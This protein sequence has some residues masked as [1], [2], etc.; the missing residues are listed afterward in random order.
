MKPI[1]AWAI[2]DRDGDACVTFGDGTPELFSSY[3]RARC[4][5]IDWRNG[6]KVIRVEIRHI[7]PKKRIK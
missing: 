5:N 2:T 7:K 1:K 6:A 3:D 4:Q